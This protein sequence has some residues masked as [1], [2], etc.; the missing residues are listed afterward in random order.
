M[1]DIVRSR[2]EDDERERVWLEF[3]EFAEKNIE[4][5]S[6]TQSVNQV[7][8]V[9]LFRRSYARHRRI[10][11]EGSAPDELIV[12]ALRFWHQSDYGTVDDG[13]GSRDSVVSRAPPPT[14]AGFYKGLRLKSKALLEY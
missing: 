2:E 8:V 4:R 6:E 3:Q 12:R 7:E 14:S 10:D 1:F 9:R 11:Q 13:Y 5:C